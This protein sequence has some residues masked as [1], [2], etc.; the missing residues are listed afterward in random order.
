MLRAL[1]VENDNFAFLPELLIRANTFGMRIVEE[2]IHFIFR[3]Q[4]VSKMHF[5]TT[6]LSYLSLLRLRIPGAPRA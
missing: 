2:P 4:G 6:T 5:L 1:T 3:R